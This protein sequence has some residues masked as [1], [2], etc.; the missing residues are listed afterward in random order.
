MKYLAELHPRSTRKALV[1]ML[2]IPVKIPVSRLASKFQS[3]G[4]H[5]PNVKC[6]Q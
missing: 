4:T 2:I 6:Q 3:C 5:L 1:L